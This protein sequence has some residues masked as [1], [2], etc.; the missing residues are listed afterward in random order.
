MKLT[1]RFEYRSIL[2][3]CG[4]VLASEHG[5]AVA[6][7]VIKCPGKIAANRSQS[8]DKEWA[9]MTG[10]PGKLSGAWIMRLGEHYEETPDPVKTTHSETIETRT[11]TEFFRVTSLAG[12]P[13]MLNCEY[14]GKITENTLL[15]RKLPRLFTVCEIKKIQSKSDTGIKAYCK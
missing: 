1:A 8:M 2:F 11:T 7:E 13:W 15:W 5:T 9:F 10:G 12:K 3:L 6:A 14:G 4:L